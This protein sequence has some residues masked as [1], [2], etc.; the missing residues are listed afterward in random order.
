M[1]NEAN[2]EP[3]ENGRD[4]D[5][6]KLIEILGEI[7]FLRDRLAQ[8]EEEAERLKEDLGH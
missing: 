1:K 2:A 4:N 8:L 6:Q 3:Y 5:T 7:L